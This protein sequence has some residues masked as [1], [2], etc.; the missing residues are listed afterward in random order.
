MAESDQPLDWYRVADPDGLPAGRVKTVTAGTYSMALTNIGGAFTA[1]GNRCPHQGGPLGEGSIEI[2][3]DGQCWLRC[4]WHGSDFDPQTGRAPGG[5]ENSGQK[6]YPV[7]V[8]NDGI[9]VG[10]EAEAPQPPR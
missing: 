9:Y 5:H 8:R 10:L 6:L 4:P 2:S 1:M 3:A 7:E